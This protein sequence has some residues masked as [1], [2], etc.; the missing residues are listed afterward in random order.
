MRACF[1]RAKESIDRFETVMDALGCVSEYLKLLLDIGGSVS[2]VS[3][4]LKRFA[5]A[6]VVTF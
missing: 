2:Q 5:H 3:F 6:D 1:D 4:L